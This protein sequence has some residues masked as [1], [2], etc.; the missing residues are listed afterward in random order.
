MTR[1]IDLNADLGEL[2][3]ERG[4]A[5]DRAILAEVSS[6]AI[7]CGGHAGD[8]ETMAAT[9]QAARE[10]GVSA[11]AHPSYPDPQ[12]FGRQTMS[13]S[14]SA[15][16][17]TLCAQMASLQDIAA[18]HGISLAHVKPH[19]A[20]YNDAAK[21]A[22]IA[23]AVAS[24]VKACFGVR[25]AL[26]GP[27]GSETEKSASQAGLPFHAEGFI[28]RTYMP[29]GSLMPR[30]EPGA[31]L[32]DNDERVEQAL[33]IARDG[34]VTDCRNG[35]VILPAKTL[36][37]HGDSPGAAETARHVR[38]ALQAQGIAIQPVSRTP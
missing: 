4:R 25:L 28:D 12:N 19:G 18:W 36:C 9:L 2:P 8:E 35:K 3:G 17:E 34:C 7:A 26:I 23:K 31:V 32:H 38:K 30:S 15:L 11:G 6:C 13:L 29:D 24:A 27:P 33:Q 5:S 37:L 22:S 21:S 10:H 20:L 16:H 1:T 14:S